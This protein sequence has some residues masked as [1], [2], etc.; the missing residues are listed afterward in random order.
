[1]FKRLQQ[2]GRGSGLCRCLAPPPTERG[3]AGI[4]NVILGKSYTMSRFERSAPEAG[5]FRKCRF[6]SDPVKRGG[7]VLS[8][9]F[10]FEINTVS[11]GD[12]DCPL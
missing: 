5:K 2:F 12:S 3:N 10:G 8:A 7:S 4:D 9:Q 1:M 11:G 6:H